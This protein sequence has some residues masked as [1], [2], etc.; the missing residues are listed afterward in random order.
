MQDCVVAMVHGHSLVPRSPSL[1]QKIPRRERGG[2]PGNKAS[3]V[4]AQ[5]SANKANEGSFG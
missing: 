3:Q 4:T 1:A 5:N 2:G